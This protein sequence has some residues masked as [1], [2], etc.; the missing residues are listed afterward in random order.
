MLQ[1]ACD[2]HTHTLFSRHAYSTV[3]ENVRAAAE[4]HFELLGITDHFSPMIRGVGP[5]GASMR[6]FQEYINMRMWPR[7]WHGVYLMHGCEADIVDLDGHLYGWD[8]PI[9]YHL[10]IAAEPPYEMLQERV[11]LQCDYV[12]ASVHEHS[13]AAG[14]TREQNTQMYLRALEHPKVLILGHTGR[15]GLDFDELAVA[16]AARDAGKL[17]EI[18]EASLFGR[19]SVSIARC[20]E[21]ARACARVG[22]M[23]STASDAHISYDVARLDRTRELL[24]GIGFPAHLV[25]TRDAQTF[26]GV[27]EEAL[28]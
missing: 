6:E 21:I 28:G 11:F 24:E 3:E 5:E 7:E 14:A 12:V 27:C 15:S 4:Q 10:S 13:W 25:A 18:N 9:T 22:C 2:T 23:V 1:I 19:Y 20:T 17:I 16:E 26:L 8:I